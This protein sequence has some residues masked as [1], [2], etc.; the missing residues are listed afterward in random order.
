MLY[1]S[2]IIF[3]DG[4]WVLGRVGAVGLEDKMCKCGIAGGRAYSSVSMRQP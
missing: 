4:E 2:S 1:I 3:M